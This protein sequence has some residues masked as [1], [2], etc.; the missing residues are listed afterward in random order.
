M[1]ITYGQKNA[2]MSTIQTQLIQFRASRYL[3]G[4]ISHLVL[5]SILFK[6]TFLKYLYVKRW[7]S[8]MKHCTLLKRT[9]QALL[10]LI[11]GVHEQSCFQIFQIRFIYLLHHQQIRSSKEVPKCCGQS[12]C[13]FFFLFWLKFV[14]NFQQHFQ[15][16]PKLAK[17]V[18]NGLK[19]IFF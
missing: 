13:Q 8:Y 14:L 15:P 17:N 2:P 16:A 19:A 12:C 4:K 3:S 18:N 1:G 7:E 11:K 9:S 10:F 5:G 6:I